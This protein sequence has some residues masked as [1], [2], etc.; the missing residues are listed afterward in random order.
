MDTLLVVVYFGR[1]QRFVLSISSTNTK[2]E[3]GASTR[4]EASFLPLP[5]SPSS[6]CQ[7]RFGGGVL[8]TDLASTELT[9]AGS[10]ALEINTVGSVGRRPSVARRRHRK[11]G[12][13]L[14]SS[15][16]RSARWEQRRGSG[17]ALG[18]KWE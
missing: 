13:P 16:R 1:P 9:E 10:D 3:G 2:V 6:P 5:A 14:P 12:E 8:R 15:A 4:K 17:S 18:E 7:I 11:G